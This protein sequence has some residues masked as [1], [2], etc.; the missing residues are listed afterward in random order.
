V[1]HANQAAVMKIRGRH[2]RRDHIFIRS[3]VTHTHDAAVTVADCE[4]LEMGRDTDRREDIIDD[5]LVG[6]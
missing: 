2:G 4:G 1:R 5:D 6:S 3:L